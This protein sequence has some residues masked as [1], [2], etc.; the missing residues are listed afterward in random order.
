MYKANKSE[1]SPPAPQGKNGNISKQQLF[2][3]FLTA[4]VSCFGAI[5]G[6]Y[7]SSKREQVNW[8]ERSEYDRKRLLYEK[9]ISLFERTVAIVNKGGLV[10]NFGSAVAIEQFKAQNVL[11]CRFVSREK[12]EHCIEKNSANI[13]KALGAGNEIQ[14]LASEFAVVLALDKAFFGKKTNQLLDKLN[15]NNPWDGDYATYEAIFVAM[16]EELQFGEI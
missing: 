15:M 1:K 7:Y 5:L 12:Q 14:A 9:R 6:S 13:D 16:Y 10:R 4:A 8:N 11:R 2:V 3:I